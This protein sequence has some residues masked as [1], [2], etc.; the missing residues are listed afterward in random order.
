MSERTMNLRCAKH[1]KYKA[2]RQPRSTCRACWIIWYS[3]GDRL[4]AL[5]DF[6]AAVDEAT[7][8][9]RRAADDGGEER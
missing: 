6:G 7:A 9:P 2:I 4:S 8:T 5:A 3:T 1:P